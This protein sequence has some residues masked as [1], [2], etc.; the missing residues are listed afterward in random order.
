MPKISITLYDHTDDSATLMPLISKK[1]EAIMVDLLTTDAGAGTVTMKTVT[2]SPKDADQDLVLHFVKNIDNSYIAAKM[3]GNPIK[4][5]DGGVTRPQGGKTGSEIYKFPNDK[6]GKPQGQF[7]ASG[8]AKIGA[9]ELM[10]NATGLTNK[11]LHNQ[12]G[13]GASPP[14]PTVNDDNRK[15]FQAALGKLP[16]QLL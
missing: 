2:S 8:Y 7:K 1:L 16:K 15:A 5:E 13:I 4:P 9:H 6:E 11:D 14:S 10:H 12:G 3:P